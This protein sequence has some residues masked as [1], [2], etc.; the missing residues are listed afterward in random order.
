[1]LS[2]LRVFFHLR[3]S[4]Q[5]KAFFYYGILVYLSVAKVHLKNYTTGKSQSI[6]I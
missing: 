6:H 3:R 4:E 2:W 1:M 5:V